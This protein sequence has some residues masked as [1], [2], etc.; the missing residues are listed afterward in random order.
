[1]SDSRASTGNPSSPADPDPASPFGARVRRC[2]HLANLDA[3]DCDRVRTHRLRPLDHLRRMASTFLG[4]E[5]DHGQAV[6][7]VIGTSPVSRHEPRR[8]RHP[9]D[10]L[11]TQEPCCA[12]SRSPPM[13]TLATTACISHLPSED[14]RHRTTT[15][16]YETTVDSLSDAQARSPDPRLGTEE[17][18]IEKGQRSRSSW[19]SCLGESTLIQA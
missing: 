3:L 11:I 14:T 13:L 7:S 6:T 2:R 15:C 16:A 18:Q 4:V 10:H 5:H 12:V 1:M 17:H 19:R 9:R 8:L